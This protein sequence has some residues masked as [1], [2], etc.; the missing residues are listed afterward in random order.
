MIYL[1]SAATTKPKQEYLDLYQKTHQSYWHHANSPYQPGQ[2]AEAVVGLA[3]EKLAKVLKI[4]NTHQ[5]LFTNGGT[6]ANNFAIY[7]ICNNYINQKGTIITTKIEHPSVLE[8]FVD[9]EKK[10]FKVFYLDVD[11]DGIVNLDQLQQ[12]LSKDTILVSIQWVNN[13]VG[14]IQPIKKVC[15]IMKN[16]PKAKLHVDGI[17]GLGKVAID[18]N[19]QDIDLFTISAHKIQGLKSSGALI[20]NSKNALNLPLKASPNQYPG[21]MDIGKAVVLAKAAEDALNY[22]NEHWEKVQKMHQ[23][24]YQE[25]T[26]IPSIVINGGKNN[27]SPYILNFSVM[28][29]NAETVM[30]Y[31]AS[32]NIYVAT[33]SACSS[34]LK[35]PQATVFAMT[36]DEARA[37]SSIRVSMS[38]KNTVEELQNLVDTL[39]LFCP[40]K[41]F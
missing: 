1:D 18:F 19:L 5:I 28:G 39:K 35:K 21:T 24:L 26:K 31:L 37:L 29:K 27:Y 13:I 7:G 20:Y 10:G 22:Q 8:P 6:E 2:K 25:L 23:F 34:K 16:F 41:Q 4:P 33:G 32:F 3:K 11:S 15:K 36:N 17:Q 40:E 38:Y 9:L 12:V 14:S 30:N